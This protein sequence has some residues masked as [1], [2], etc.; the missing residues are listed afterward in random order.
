MLK[1]LIVGYM[2]YAVLNEIYKNQKLS[3]D[4]AN[5]V[6]RHN[7]VLGLIT[8]Y[9]QDGLDKRELREALSELGTDFEFERIIKKI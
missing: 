5:V 4:T 8:R 1:K 7:E 2:I 3:T 6:F 9:L